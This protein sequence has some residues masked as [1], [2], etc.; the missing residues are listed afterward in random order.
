MTNIFNELAAQLTDAGITT[1]AVCVKHAVTKASAFDVAKEKVI[2]KLK[3][4]IECAN[5]QENGTNKACYT[6]KHGIAYVGI[7][8]GNTYLATDDGTKWLDVENDPQKITTL[9]EVLI[10]AV[11][12]GSFDETLV[13][14]VEREQELSKVRY[15][16]QKVNKTAKK[17]AAAKAKDFTNVKPTIDVSAIVSN[18][19]N[20]SN[21]SETQNEGAR[22]V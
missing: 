9:L 17:Q 18:I 13:K 8:Y 15:A 2:A 7:K 12:S 4:S 3:M 5:G 22:L 11:A 14:A 20:S 16:K 1:N 6:I 19:D 21:H 10:S